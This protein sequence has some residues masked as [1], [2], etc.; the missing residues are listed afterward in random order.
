MSE[1]FDS[2]LEAY[3][4]DY[5]ELN[6]IVATMFG[7]EGYNHLFPNPLSDQ[8]R[9]DLED[10]H[11]KYLEEAKS[12][13]DEDLTHNQRVSKDIVIWNCET[14]MEQL[15]FRTDLLP[16]DQTWSLNLLAGQWAS[17][18]GAQPFLTPE[19]YQ[20]WLKRLEGYL[21][22]MDMAQDKMREGME[23]GYVLP[24]SLI[25][26]IPPTLEPF[27]SDNL[28]EHLFY[29]PVQ[30]FPD[31]FTEE[32]KQMLTGQYSE[33]IRERIVPAYKSLLEF[34]KG[35]YLEAGRESS[36]TDG[37]PQGKAYYS[38]LIKT[39]TTSRMSAD[40]IFELGLSEVARIRGE[41]ELVRKEVG[42]QGDMKAFFEFVRTSQ[43][44]MPYQ[45]PREVIDHFNVIHDRMKPKLELLFDQKPE[46]G[47][48]V[49][50]TEA[51]REK[52]TGPHY[53]PGSGDGSRPGVFY[54]SIPDV[55]QYNNAS[56]E[57]LFL[58][59][60]IP[61]HHYQIALT[62]ENEQLPDFRR[63]LWLNAYGEGWALYTESLGKELGLYTDPYQYFG[64]LMAEMHRA[65]R[66]VVDVGLHAK[67]WTREEAIQY[68]L[69]NEAL[70]EEEIISEV[71]R[72][73]AFPGQALGYKIGQLKISE[74]RARAEGELGDAFDIRE[75]HNIIL[76]TGCVPLTTLEKIV[77]L[78]IADQTQST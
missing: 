57:S 59:E 26:K 55:T 1:K 25:K 24:G 54:V 39:Q 70:G 22:W 3:F 48:E 38:H 34:I 9:S 66:L 5:L 53:N 64:N 68:C 69:D 45:D 33:I 13:E 6:P 52:S 32:E 36:G 28:E 15:K 78:W 14:G 47:F 73:M 67:S 72:Y 8:Y 43:E 35:D 49:R 62:Q 42:F 77:D 7:I 21:E 16:V 37:I 18:A 17:G 71:E 76:E 27:T 4:R 30:N 2:M 51:F 44:L 11:G 12:F 46:I 50:R 10:F 29:R 74:L 75:F 56:D 20:N 63:Y 61:G 23:L 19:D 40:E 65:V 41:M 31:S 58:H 60:A